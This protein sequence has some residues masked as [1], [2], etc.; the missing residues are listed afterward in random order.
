[1]GSGVGSGVGSIVGSGVAVVL[2]LGVAG[3]G[4]HGTAAASE[5][6]GDG[7]SNDGMT[8]LASGDGSGKQVG[9]GLGEP[10]P[11]PPTN[12]PHVRPYGRNWEL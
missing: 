9:D 12:G 1:V 2:G 10:Q 11:S 6:D 7:I 5:P 4:V 8:P 3:G